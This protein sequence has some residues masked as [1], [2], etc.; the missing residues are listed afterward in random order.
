VLVVVQALPW[1]LAIEVVRR[2]RRGR[3]T[4]RPYAVAAVAA[5]T[6]FAVYTPARIAWQHGELR[7]RHHVVAVGGDGTSRPPPFRIAF[8]ADLQQDAHTDGQRAAE[9]ID[10]MNATRPDIVLSGGDW[11]NVGP[12][13]ID[14][15]ARSAAR[16]RS[17]LGTFTV[18]GDHEHFIYL[19]RER[20]V[21]AVT[22][23]MQRQ[24]VAM[25]HNEVRRFDHHGRTIAV[26]FLT[27][28]YPSRTPRPE[29]ERLLDAT[30]GADVSILV[31][32]Q[33]D[34]TTAALARDRVDLILAAHT[35]GG[36]VNPVIGLWHFPLARLET[37]YIDGRYQLGRTTIIVTAGIGYS[38][39]PFRYA[40]V[41]SVETIDL[42]W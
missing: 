26:A 35:H 11:V 10:R 14:G 23:A 20:S 38:L 32:H 9:V 5:V 15:A 17:R 7:W 2:V 12:D 27:F 41:G 29:I 1:L 24:G 16:A 28:N 36:Q 40:S 34:A 8:I 4:A 30:A 18:R 39:V 42:V 37:P 33:L 6:I 21:A 13:H 25:L 31:T 19:D 3:P 22:E